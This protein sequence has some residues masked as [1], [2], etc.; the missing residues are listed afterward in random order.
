MIRGS[1]KQ[2]NIRL[3]REIVERKMWKINVERE[4]KWINSL[5]ALKIYCAVIANQLQK[6]HG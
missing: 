1:Q 3:H 2:S 5:F 4:K 6:E